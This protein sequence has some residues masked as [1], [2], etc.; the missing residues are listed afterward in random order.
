MGLSQRSQNKLSHLPH[1]NP[2][3]RV[4]T[5]NFINS[6]GSV[7]TLTLKEIGS[8][9]LGGSFSPSDVKSLALYSTMKMFA[10]AIIL[11]LSGGAVGEDLGKLFL[12]TK[13]GGQQ[14][15]VGSNSSLLQ[16]GI[17]GAG[18]Q[19][20]GCF[21]IF[22][23]ENFVKP[24]EKVGWARG[25]EFEEEIV[26]KSVKFLQEDC[27]DVSINGVS[28]ITTVIFIGVGVCVVAL[29]LIGLAVFHFNKY[30][31]ARRVRPPEIS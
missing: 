14:E 9:G 31:E 8:L 23:E 18:A 22:E 28:T 12:Y 11:L 16:I 2:L 20:F 27:A 17:T 26:V 5:G 1:P 3:T 7:A 30:R 25:L 4:A 24:L 13:T 10:L 19:G 15:F 21:V 29:V 6:Y